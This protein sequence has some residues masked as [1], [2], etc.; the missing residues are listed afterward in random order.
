VEESTRG[1]EFTADGVS[2]ILAS[3]AP[4][5]RVTALWAGATCVFR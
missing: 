5:A 3:N 2:G 1:I 4:D